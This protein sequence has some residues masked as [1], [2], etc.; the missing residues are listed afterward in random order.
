MELLKFLDKLISKVTRGICI[1]SMAIIFFLFL[2]NVFVRIFN[3]IIRTINGL[4]QSWF[5]LAE[6]DNLIN[7][8]IP[9]FSQSDGWIQLFLVWVIFLGAQELV[10]TRGHFVVDVITDRLVGTHLG[11][12]FRVISTIIEFIMYAVICYYGFVLVER[13]NAY[14]LEIPWMQKRWYYMVIPVSAFFMSCYSIRDVIAAIK[15]P[16]KLTGVKTA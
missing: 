2:L 7:I 12:M 1:V 3:D 8:M 9:N 13:A 5:G 15:T 14:M 16:A 10:R 11:K 4:G 6:G